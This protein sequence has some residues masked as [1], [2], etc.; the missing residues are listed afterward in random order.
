MQFAHI[1]FIPGLFFISSLVLQRWMEK[2]AFTNIIKL[3]LIGI[4]A[5]LVI[6]LILSLFNPIFDSKPHH[7]TIFLKSIIIDGFLFSS[8]IIVSLYFA[9]DFFCDI[10]INLDWSM[11]SLLSASYIFGI[12]TVVDILQAFSVNYPGNFFQY[13]SLIPF[14]LTVSLI[15]GFGIPKY[16]DSFGIAEKII[17]AVFTI[18]IPAVLFTVYS[19]LKFYNYI[20]QY[21]IIIPFISL[22]LIFE[23]KDFKYF[24]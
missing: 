11:T 19:Y 3:Y 21:L 10:S 4:A 8:L 23:I 24:R 14:L 13:L 12:Y 16:M 17:W 9:I 2:N 6:D 22:A 15:I 20:E 7:M 1:M 5:G 18:V